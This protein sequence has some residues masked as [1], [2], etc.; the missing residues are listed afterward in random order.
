MTAVWVDRAYWMS[1]C[2]VQSSSKVWIK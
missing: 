2:D 1:E